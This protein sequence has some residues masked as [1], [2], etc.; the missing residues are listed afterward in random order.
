MFINLEI[1]NRRFCTYYIMQQKSWSEARF[2]LALNGACY[3]LYMLRT[4][5]LYSLITTLV[6]WL[7]YIKLLR[8]IKYN[9][10]YHL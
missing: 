9:T 4:W 3:F 1:V 8:S 6:Y 2:R 5:A 7:D 10:Y